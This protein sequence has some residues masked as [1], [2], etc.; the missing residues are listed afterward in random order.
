MKNKEIRML[1]SPIELREGEDKR[2][3]LQGYA[4]TFDT[5]SADIGF[6]ETI[7]RGALDS[8]DMSNVVLNFNHDMNKPLARNSKNEGVGSLVLTIDDK[9]LFFDA[10][11]TDTS[12]ARDLIENMKNGI[13]Q[14]CSFAFSLDYNDK[15]AQKWDWDDGNRV[16]DFRT[17]MKI[18]KLYDVSI[19]TNPAYESTSCTTYERAKE[20]HDNELQEAKKLRK[21][22]IE[23]ELELM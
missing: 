9:G 20:H 11:P 6:R 12:Y 14:K 19:V 8:T 13:V 4:I 22:K 2:T 15:D 10:I 1:S 18:E 7:R 23:L 5:I 16:Y 17:I 3:H 21:R